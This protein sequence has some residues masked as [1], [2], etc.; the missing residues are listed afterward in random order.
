MPK[1]GKQC[2]TML[3][4]NALVGNSEISVFLEV[5]I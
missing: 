1:L 5:R 4:P 3:T 2:L